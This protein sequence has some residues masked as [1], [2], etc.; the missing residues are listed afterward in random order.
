METEFE[1]KIL[2]IDVAY[3]QSKLETIGANMRLGKRKMRRFVYELYPPQENAW[4]RLRDDGEKITLCV[5]KIHAD[6]IDGT[7]Q[8]EKV[9]GNFYKTHHQIL[10]SGH[11]PIAY[12]ENERISYMLN[13]AAV[14]IDFWPGIPPHLEIE[15]SSV[16]E[17]ENMVS[18]LG[19]TMENTTT[20]N[21]PDIYKLYGRCIEDYNIE[22][23]YPGKKRIEIL[24]SSLV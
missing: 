20:I 23:F 10:K 3:I 12:Q 11:L 17:I 22:N 15:G 16:E 2:D 13:G 7:K 18:R 19:Y 9:V 4:L 8:H 5:K 6:T 24:E 21:V 1:V 14:E